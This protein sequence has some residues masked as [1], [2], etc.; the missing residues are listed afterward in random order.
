MTAKVTFKPIKSLDIY[1]WIRINLN[2]GLKESNDLAKT[3]LIDFYGD[4]KKAIEFY[5]YLNNCN[6][7]DAILFIHDSF[8]HYTDAICAYCFTEEYLEE[9]R[10]YGEEFEELNK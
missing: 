10:K 7:T 8:Q 6:E 3:G 5:E 1:R 4:Y 9:L 2:L